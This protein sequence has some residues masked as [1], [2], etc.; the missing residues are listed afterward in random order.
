MDVKERE[1]ILKKAKLFFRGS[2]VANHAA[3]LSS[4]GR[5]STYNYNPFLVKYLAKFFAGKDDSDSIA[6]VLLY[7]RVL[8]T[9]INTSFGSNIQKF[10]SSVLG[11]YGSAV[12]GID[13]EFID[14]VDGRKK[15][16]QLKSGPETINK[17]DVETVS[18]H[19]DSI[20]NLAR[21]N[22]LDLRASDLVVGVLYGDRGDLSTFYKKL[23]KSYE[24]IP[25]QEFWERLT[26]DK[27]FYVQLSDAF[28]EVADTI[29]GHKKIL[30]TLKK[31]SSDIQ[32]SS[33]FN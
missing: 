10:I 29:G 23:H 27:H 8:G 22:N 13:I 2:I 24:V 30:E 16:C 33:F 18:R 4:L 6:K 12:S 3:K 15:Y 11:K 9:S 7:P 5:L 14:T 25:G 21:T 19:F 28:G 31:L 17:D 32:S 1:E 26:G 20:K